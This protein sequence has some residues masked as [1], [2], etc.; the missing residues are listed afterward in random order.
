MDKKKLY[1][2]LCIVMDF[3]FSVSNVC[4][5]HRIIGDKEIV[6]SCYGQRSE[7]C[8]IMKLSLVVVVE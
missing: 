7:Q 1:S 2:E 5:M 3:A 4:T 8:M 6:I